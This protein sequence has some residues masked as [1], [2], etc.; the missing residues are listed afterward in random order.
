MVPNF[1]TLFVVKADK[2]GARVA[3]ARQLLS[4]VC[5]SDVT[6]G[7]IF[8]QMQALATAYIELA[9]VDVENKRIVKGPCFF[10][11]HVLRALIN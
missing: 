5:S 9:N 3:L 11:I 6:R 8:A 2:G 1:I 7:K 4:E 10:P